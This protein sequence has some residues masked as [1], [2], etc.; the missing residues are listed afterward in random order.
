MITHQWNLV[1]PQWSITTYPLKGLNLKKKKKNSKKLKKIWQGCGTTET[2]TLWVE[3]QSGKATLE[4]S[5]ASS[6]KGKHIPTLWPSNSTPSS[7]VKRNKNVS[8]QNCL[9]KNICRGFSHSR[10]NLGTTKMLTNK[11]MDKQIVDFPNKGTLL[12]N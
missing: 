8:S 2:H 4:N 5:L 7:L 3:M 6:S 10:Q 12:R 1:T 11:R 9:N